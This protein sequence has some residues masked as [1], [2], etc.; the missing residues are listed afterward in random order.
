MK[1]RLLISSKHLLIFGGNNSFG[2]IILLNI[3]L[4]EMKS[5]INL[6]QHEK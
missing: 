4:K 5:L 6:N 2:K 1:Y 3:L